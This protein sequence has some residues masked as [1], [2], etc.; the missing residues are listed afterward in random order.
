MAASLALPAPIKTCF[1]NGCGKPAVAD[2]WKC[3]FH[4]N[5]GR[6]LVAN[7]TNQA[8]ARSLCARHGGK[9]KCFVDGCNLSARLANVCYKHGA[10]NLNKKCIHEG[11][12]KPAQFQQKCV[13][14]GGG[15]KC[16]VD[17]CTAHARCAGLCCRH[18]REAGIVRESK[19]SKLDR[20]PSSPISCGSLTSDDVGSGDPTN[21]PSSV[22]LAETF[23]TDDWDE[24]DWEW[25]IAPMEPLALPSRPPIASKLAM[26]VLWTNDLVDFLRSL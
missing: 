10:R 16:K 5:R 20:R 4:R 12:T 2:S 11:C 14:H 9:K 15:R 7:C 18:G 26:D 19:K 13:R 21:V 17:G 8:Y 6:C 22:V 3:T 24:L 1:F 25:A 23:L